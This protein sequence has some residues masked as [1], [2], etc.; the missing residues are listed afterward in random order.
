MTS[1]ANW[2]KITMQCAKDIT[3]HPVPLISILFQEK[4]E[5]YLMFM[6]SKT[7]TV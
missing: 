6:Y 5:A 3:T 4:I 7:A 2:L 1:P